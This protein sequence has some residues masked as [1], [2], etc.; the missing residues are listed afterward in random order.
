MQTE[1][2]DKNISIFTEEM[3]T[4]NSVLCATHEAL[5]STY[6]LIYLVNLS[7]VQ[8]QC[9]MLLGVLKEFQKINVHNINYTMKNI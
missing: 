2:Q 5:A 7:S 6:S 8:C 3:L 4:L 1:Q 9:K